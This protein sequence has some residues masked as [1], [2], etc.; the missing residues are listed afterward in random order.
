MDWMIAALSERLSTRR[1]RRSMIVGLGKAGVVG[2]HL[3]RA[4]VL[5]QM[6]RKPFPTV[7]AVLRPVRR[8]LVR[9]ILQRHS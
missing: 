8:L 5:E 6:L 4:W 9:R 2:G 3:P 7:A 1:S